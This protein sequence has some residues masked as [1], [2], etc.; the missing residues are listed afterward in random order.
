[1]KLPLFSIGIGSRSFLFTVGVFKDIT[2]QPP[3][4]CRPRLHPAL[5][6]RD[7]LR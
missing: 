2:S 1:M 3:G 5:Q 4:G 6:G 7:H